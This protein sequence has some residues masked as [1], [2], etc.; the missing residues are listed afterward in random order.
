MEN[1]LD[2]STYHPRENSG[3]RST[4]RLNM[5]ASFAIT[6]IIDMF[7]L[8]FTIVMD[9]IDDVVF[10]ITDET[11]S[12]LIT[13][14]LKTIN[15]KNN[16]YTLSKLIKDDVFYKLFDH[17]E[18]LN[19]EIE[20]IYLITNSPIKHSFK[21]NTTKKNSEIYVSNLDIPMKDL[22]EQVCIAIESNMRKNQNFEE[23]GLSE[24]FKFSLWD[25]TVST[26][27]DLAKSKL[28]ELCTQKFPYMD[29]KSLTALHQTLYE[30]LI[31]K[32]SFEFELEENIND[33]L[34]HKSYSSNE[35]K[36]L[37]YKATSVGALTMEVIKDDYIKFNN[38]LEEVKWNKALADLKTKIFQ[39]PELFDKN[40]Q[41]IEEVI[42]S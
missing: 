40:I 30:I 5:Q 9:I 29:V 2:L 8:N 23:H 35:L 31:R 19:T 17:I 25:V 4:N 15:S 14:Q 7:D 26:H 11:S 3:S 42:I 22:H 18:Q 1:F 13:Y 12:K 37:I 36:T 21:D 20:F 32:Q 33:V 34:P 10:L 28:T 27:Y 24:K 39:F 41:I 16:S 6:K 38:L